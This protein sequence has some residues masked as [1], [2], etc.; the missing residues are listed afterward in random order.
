[1]LKR[2]SDRLDR[3]ENQLAERRSSSRPEDLSYHGWVERGDEDGQQE[4]L[5]IVRE[6][7]KRGELN[8]GIA[9]LE[10]IAANEH[11][12]SCAYRAANISDANLCKSVAGAYPDATPNPMLGYAEGLIRGRLRTLESWLDWVTEKYADERQYEPTVTRRE[13]LERR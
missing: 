5:N 4:A 1:M 8:L 2:L 10:I 7:F 11:H 3:R 9:R 13:A 6:L 12:R